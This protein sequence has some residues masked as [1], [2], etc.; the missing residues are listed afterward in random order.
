M[1]IFTRVLDGC[2]LVYRFSLENC[3]HLFI[4][5]F[6]IRCSRLVRGNV[7]LIVYILIYFACKLAK[8]K[9]VICV[10]RTSTYDVFINN[11]W[12]TS[13]L[14]VTFRNY[15]KASILGK[16]WCALMVFFT[17]CSLVYQTIMSRSSPDSFCI[18]SVVSL[19]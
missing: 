11:Y 3:Y 5:A 14:K 1:V 17:K 16:I 4:L 9:N 18:N 19:S 15:K 7:F 13:P 10:M 8:S 6:K 2:L 12:G